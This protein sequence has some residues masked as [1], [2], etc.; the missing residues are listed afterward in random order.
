ME[1]RGDGSELSFADCPG[2]CAGGITGP[3]GS[4]CVELVCGFCGA[5]GRHTTRATKN[6]AITAAALAKTIQFV[7]Q[8]RVGAASAWR[9]KAL[10]P[11]RMQRGRPRNHR[12]ARADP[13]AA[14][15]RLLRLRSTLLYSVR[16]AS[17]L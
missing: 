16:I 13:R 14:R 8:V 10:V 3:D 2:P 17:Q 5:S 9:R 11:A 6:A 15:H 12:D 1:K 4:S 7:S